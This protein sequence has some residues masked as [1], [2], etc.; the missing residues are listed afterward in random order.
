MKVV[1]LLAPIL[2]GLMLDIERDIPRQQ[3]KCQCFSQLQVTNSYFRTINVFAPE[4][5]KRTTRA[6]LGSNFYET[7]STK[8][9]VFVTLLKYVLSLH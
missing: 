6:F 9:V 8:L 7:Y 1:N 2:V 4:T 5:K 3:Q